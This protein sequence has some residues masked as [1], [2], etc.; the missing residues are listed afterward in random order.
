MMNKLIIKK[1][2]YSIKDHA[3]NVEDTEDMVLIIHIQII[4][5]MNLIIIMDQDI[6]MIMLLT[7]PITIIQDH[8]IISKRNNAPKYTLVI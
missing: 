5:I 2:Q 4:I 7:A 3:V 1:L 8:P 6:I